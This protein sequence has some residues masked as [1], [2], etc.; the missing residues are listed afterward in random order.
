MSVIDLFIF[1][2]QLLVLFLCASKLLRN[3]RIANH[4]KDGNVS[5]CFCVRYCGERSSLALNSNSN[6]IVISF[7]SD[8]SYTDKGFSAQYK[9]YDPQNRK[10]H[11]GYILFSVCSYSIN[12]QRLLV[13]VVAYVAKI[14]NIF[15]GYP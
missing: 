5:F 3:V 12:A 10:D 13:V 8:S 6:T 15:I 7:H 11:S 1:K 9:A 14:L 2:M 4:N